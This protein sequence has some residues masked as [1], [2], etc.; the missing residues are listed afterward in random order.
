MNTEEYCDDCG[1]KCDCV[2]SIKNNNEDEIQKYVKI[3]LSHKHLV[4]EIIKR[5]QLELQK[6]KE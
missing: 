5:V 6:I 4:H 2:H 1:G 3:L